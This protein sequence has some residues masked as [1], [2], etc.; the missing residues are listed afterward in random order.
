VTWARTRPTP[1]AR[2]RISFSRSDA[3]VLKEVGRQFRLRE[4]RPDERILGYVTHLRRQEDEFDGRVT[5]KVLV[6][7][8]V[9][10]LT[11]DLSKVDYEIAVQAH[12]NQNPI[13]VIGNLE[14]EGQRW[15]LVAPRS[16]F[17]VEDDDE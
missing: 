1:V 8:R 2:E 17:V 5:I 9:R 4:P 15:H 11:A 3:E 12:Q 16:I 13:S 7:G 6:D 14:T 10:S